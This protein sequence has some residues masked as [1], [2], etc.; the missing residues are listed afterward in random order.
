MKSR[1]NILFRSECR[2]AYT[3]PASINSFKKRKAECEPQIKTPKLRPKTTGSAKNSI[4]EACLFCYE[5]LKDFQ[6]LP[7]KRQKNSAFSN[8][9]TIEFKEHVLKKRQKRVMSGDR[10]LLRGFK[11]T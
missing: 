3:N 5:D 1:D 11:I 10:L 2:K 6:K 4:S 7:H 8:V 9:E